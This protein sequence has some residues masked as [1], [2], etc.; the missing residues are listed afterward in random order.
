MLSSFSS[1]SL[2]NY[3]HF[4]DL[5]VEIALSHRYVEKR[6]FLRVKRIKIIC[7]PEFYYMS[8][9]LNKLLPVLGFD[10]KINYAKLQINRFKIVEKST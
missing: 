9:G 3:E 10:L 2:K 7:I 4:P 5:G 8:S 6:W 1:Q